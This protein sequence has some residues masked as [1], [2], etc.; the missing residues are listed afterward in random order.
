M[1]IN[2]VLLLPFSP[3]RFCRSDVH[4]LRGRRRITHLPGRHYEQAGRVAR[5]RERSR[6]RKRK[7]AAKALRGEGIR[8]RL[9]AARR[10]HKRTGGGS[11]KRHRGRQSMSWCVD[12]MARNGTMGGRGRVT[13]GSRRG[14]AGKARGYQRLVGLMALALREGVGVELAP[15]RMYCKKVQVS[16]C[17]RGAGTA[18]G[19]SRRWHC[20]GVLVLRRNAGIC[21]RVLA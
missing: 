6:W 20:R 9:S 19:C 15:R 12:T 3:L 2:M 1:P 4:I 17:R 13:A 8:L 21:K 14:G 10:S 5:R 16:G 7:G 18:E 11:R